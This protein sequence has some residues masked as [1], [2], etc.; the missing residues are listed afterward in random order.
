MVD[1]AAAHDLEV[2]GEQLAFGLWVVKAVGETHAIDRI[3]RNA[4]D[5]QRR[6]DADDFVDCRD[7]VVAVMELWARCGIGFDLRRPPDGHRVARA[8]EVRG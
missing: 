3:L 1:G 4:V 8:A 7:D 2:L 6:C 5:L